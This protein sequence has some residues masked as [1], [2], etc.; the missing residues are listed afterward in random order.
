MQGVQICRAMRLL[1][2]LISSDLDSYGGNVAFFFLHCM[3]LQ[4][5]SFQQ[6]WLARA[7]FGFS[8][9]LFSKHSAYINQNISRIVIQL[10]LL[11][12]LGLSFVYS[13]LMTSNPVMSLLYLIISIYPYLFLFAKQ[14]LCNMVAFLQFQ[15]QPHEKVCSISSTFTLS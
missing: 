5:L 8:S 13:T 14:D 7:S 9:R 10:Q 15:L 12:V 4:I 1:V 11:L 6:G 3:H 2:F